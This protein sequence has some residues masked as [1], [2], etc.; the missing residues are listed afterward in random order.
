MNQRIRCG[1]LLSALSAGLRCAVA[2]AIILPTAG[3]AADAGSK[4]LREQSLLPT[5]LHLDPAGQSFDLGSLPL[6]MTLSPGG[7]R[8]AVLLSGWREQGLQIVD[9]RTGQVLQTLP[10]TAAFLGLAYSADGTL[11]ASG[12]NEDQV[13]RYA[14]KNGLMAPDRTLALAPKEAGKEAT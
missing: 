7:D 9:P 1:L 3:L 10:Q 13:V 12:G 5:G 11:Y 14:L 6:A 2:F 4:T 8:L